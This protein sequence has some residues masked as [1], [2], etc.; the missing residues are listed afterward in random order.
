M[1]IEIDRRAELPKPTELEIQV[2]H[3]FDELE[4]G[5]QIRTKIFTLLQPLKEKSA[6][7]HE[8]YE[9]SLRVG[10]LAKKIAGFLHLEEKPLF[11]AGLLHDLG[12][13]KIRSDLLGKTQAWT[14]EDTKEIEP[15]VTIGY[16]LL[17]GKFDFSADIAVGHHTSQKNGYPQ[18]LPTSLHDYSEETRKIIPEYRRL[19]ALADIYDALHRE[20]GKLGVKRKLTDTQ[21]EEQMLKSNHDK[22]GLIEDLYG[23]GIFINTVIF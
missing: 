9:H 8:H 17:K 10:L 7:H 2:Y 11:F 14:E 23:A 19:L 16:D 13:Q 6:I 4:I 21:I 18:D 3:V 20:D 5:P 15:H 12:K 22:K 1:V